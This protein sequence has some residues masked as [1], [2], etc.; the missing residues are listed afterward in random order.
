MFLLNKN[1]LRIIER[2]VFLGEVRYRVQVV[3]TNIVF[4]VKALDEEEAINKA[5]EIAEKIG[6]SEEDV[7][8]IRER[9]KDMKR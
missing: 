7:E 3:G 1:D 8:K 5:L 4:N 9:Y 6:L 2:Y